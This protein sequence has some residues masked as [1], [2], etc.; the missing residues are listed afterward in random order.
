MDADTQAAS[1]WI[2]TTPT[3]SYPSLAGSLTVDTVIVGGGIAGISVAHQLKEKGQRVALIEA[4]KI[5]EGTTGNTTAK[6]TSLHGLPYTKLIKHYGEAGARTYG[7]ANEAAIDTI[8][9]IVKQYAIDCDFLRLPAYTYAQSE[10]DREKV[11]AEAEAAQ[12]IG[13][14]AQYVDDVPLPYETFGAVMFDNQAQ[15]HV[16]KYLLRLAELIDDDGSFVFEHTKATD[17]QVN[18]DNCQL[19]TDKGIITARDIVVATHAPFYDPDGD[20]KDLFEFKDY[21]LGILIAEDTPRGEFFSTGKEPHSIRYQPTSDGDVIIIGGKSEAEMEAE[22]PDEAY[23]LVRKDYS[24]KF[25]IERV[26]YQWFTEDYA[27]EDGASYIGQLSRNVPHIYVATGFNGW[28]MTNGV[29]AG[30]I[31]SDRITGVSNPWSKFF[32]TFTREQYAA[33]QA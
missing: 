17:I 10:A 16:R 33:H 25:T 28:G 21:A 32:D 1:I 24:D 26:A 22:T 19:I 20:Y 18:E 23:R 6:V 29:V 14:P 31:L 11:R 15:F 8:E 5:V 27:T 9:A 4:D 12:S 30:M 3:T 13:L 2:A 7:E